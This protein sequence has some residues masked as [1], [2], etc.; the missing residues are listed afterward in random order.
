[1]LGSQDAAFICCDASFWRGFAPFSVCTTSINCNRSCP[2]QAM[3]EKKFAFGCPLILLDTL[4]HFFS[5]DA[6]SGRYKGTM[7]E[8]GGCT[9]KSPESDAVSKCIARFYTFH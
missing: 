5:L 2:A 4:M 7:A 8:R 1:M 9:M 3:T 6:H